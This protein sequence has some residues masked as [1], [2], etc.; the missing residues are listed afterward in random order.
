VPIGRIEPVEA[1][2]LARHDHPVGDL[3]A[4]ASKCGVDVCAFAVSFVAVRHVG[5]EA[6]GVVH[7]FQDVKTH[8]AG[9]RIDSS[10]FVRM[11]PRKSTTVVGLTWIWTI[12]TY[13]PPPGSRPRVCRRSIRAAGAGFFERRACSIITGIRR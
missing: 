5:D 11:A 4:E 7:G 3:F 6:G 8:V 2:V 13:M 10:W 12:V 9:S 1:N